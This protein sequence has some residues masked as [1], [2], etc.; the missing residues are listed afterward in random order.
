MPESKTLL[1]Q[2]I[3]AI[4]GFPLGVIWGAALVTGAACSLHFAR[5]AG[6]SELEMYRICVLAIVA[7]VLGSHLLGLY[8]YRSTNSIPDVW[9]HFWEGGKSY[10][11]GLFGG[12][13]A[14]TVF[15]L[16]RRIP[17]LPMLSAMVPGL[18]LGYALGRIACFINGDDYGVRASG[19]FTVQYPNGSEA[20][21][22]H[23]L[24]QQVLASDPLSLSVVPIQLAHS[25]LGLAIFLVARRLRPEH[26]L[27][28]FA[29]LYG[30]GRF[31]IE[32]LRGDFEPFLAGLSVHQ[33]LSVGLIAVAAG[34][35]ALQRIAKLVRS[36]ARRESSLI[37]A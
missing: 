37:H 7:G 29:V 11:G 20:F 26:R 1:T 12:A 6:L 28:A 2:L 25:L 8:V 3:L 22:S 13:A 18:A 9:W 21:Y 15:C 10:Y 30:V 35:V 33:V 5:R 24:K 23:A 17:P 31:L 27:V 32:M 19:W 16:A 4:Q 14:A 34:A 36:P